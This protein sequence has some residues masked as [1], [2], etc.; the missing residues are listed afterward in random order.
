[1]GAIK[2][3]FIWVFLSSLCSAFS[4]NLLDLWGLSESED[5]DLSYKNT[6]GIE[7]FSYVGDIAIEQRSF[8]DDLA[9]V[10]IDVDPDDDLEDDAIR[11]QVSQVLEHMFQQRPD[12]L[13]HAIDCNNF[14]QNEHDLMLKN[15][16]LREGLDRN[17]RYFLIQVTDDDPHFNEN[18]NLSGY[19]A[20]WDRFQ[21]G[22]SGRCNHHIV[23][24]KRGLTV[25]TIAHQVAQL[26]EE[27][28]AFTNDN[29]RADLQKS[30]EVAAERQTL[31][32]SFLNEGFE[33]Y[34]SEG[35]RVF[36][37]CMEKSERD[38]GVYLY[39]G[40]LFLKNHD[41]EL[42]NLLKTYYDVPQLPLCSKNKLPYADMAADFDWA[43]NYAHEFE[44]GIW[45][46]DLEVLSTDRDWQEPSLFELAC[47]KRNF[48]L[49]KAILESS[50]F[51]AQY[52]LNDRAYR[53][54]F[55]FLRAL[56]LDDKK[57]IVDLLLETDC[58][59]RPLLQIARDNE[60]VAF[61]FQFLRK[62]FNDWTRV[63]SNALFRPLESELAHVLIPNAWNLA[64]TY[65]GHLADCSLLEVV[66]L[67]GSIEL[68]NHVSDV[69]KIN[70]AE[71]AAAT[72]RTKVEGILLKID[73]DIAQE[74]RSALYPNDYFN[75]WMASLGK[76]F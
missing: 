61:L 28:L 38:L 53:A 47:Y 42:Y 65:T 11:Q 58:L 10:L 59:K 17:K 68:F 2:I 55:E 12:L 72:G 18:A 26:I 3:F 63:H 70:L 37:N 44:E 31:P 6:S 43:L 76:L 36:L 33:G 5:D 13:R 19:Y 54:L 29:F 9:R 49:V 32:S 20:C 35:M 30:Y 69:A 22:A 48:A 15:E 50:N 14:W 39:D 40:E 66:I 51:Q 7:S 34:W 56:D 21:E 60:D 25:G 16:A 57:L 1:M 4:T 27:L 8:A 24:K 67:M 75:Q 45:I 41:D 46:N 23:L 64:L 62:S 52:I 71:L 73:P 74:I